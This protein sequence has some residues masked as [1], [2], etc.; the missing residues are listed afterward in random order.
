MLLALSVLCLVLGS[1]FI[2]MRATAFTPDG[3]V[4]QA[5]T[6]QGEG[7]LAEK[8]TNYVQDEVLPESK[9]TE[10]ASQVVAPLPI[11]QRQKTLLAT[12]IAT[13]VRS[14]V[15]NAVNAFFQS[16]PGQQFAAALSTRLSTE[17]VKLVEDN[18]GVFRFNGDTIVLDTQPI[19]EGVRAQAEDLLGPLAKYLPPPPES[20]RQVV[21]VQG[22]YVVT[23]QNAI[24]LIWLMSWLLPLLFVLLLIAG[25]FAARERRP[26]AFRTAIAVIIGVAITVITVRIARSVITG[27]V[28]EGPQQD[29]V[30]AILS[31]ATVNLV[32]QTLLIVLIAAIVSFLLW[33]FGPDKPARYARGWIAARAHDLRAGER[34]EAGRVTEF[35]R[36][37]RAHLEITG[38]V[39]TILAL[40]LVPNITGFTWALAL[41]SLAIW[42]LLIEYA[43][44]PR[45]MQAIANWIA[46]LRHKST[47]G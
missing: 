2:W 47:T 31:A 3:Y 29:V 4:A 11:D 21:L 6:V 36:R 26:A 39:L 23:I 27:L 7:L 45:W 35:A 30:G 13:T 1:L 17:I 8:V 19:A 15:G 14:Q 43:A 38:A 46:D 18:T 20:Y 40:M 28:Q 34:R 24:T 16:G 12:A 44:C 42:V 22:D 33:L 32:D 10:L 37:Y 9:A 5:L 25:L 41:I